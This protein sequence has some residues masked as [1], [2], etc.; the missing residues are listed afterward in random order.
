MHYCPY[1][2]PIAPGSDETNEIFIY[3]YVRDRYT[4][5]FIPNARVYQDGHLIGITDSS[6]NPINITTAKNVS[7]QYSAR[8][9]GYAES[10][11][12]DGGAAS[13][14]ATLYLDPALQNA[15]KLHLNITPKTNMSVWIDGV[16]Q[17]EANGNNPE[18]G[19]LYNGILERWI[20]IGDHTLYITALNHRPYGPE[21]I[22]VTESGYTQNIDLVDLGTL[23]YNVVVES[24]PTNIDR[25]GGTGNLEVAVFDNFESP[26]TILK[27]VPDAY[28][29]F[30]VNSLV[31]D[32][33][34]HIY[35]ANITFASYAHS[36]ASTFGS[37]IVSA[38][39]YYRG[40]DG[41]T[42]DSSQGKVRR[43][44]VH[45]RPYTNEE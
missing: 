42:V 21:V 32:P 35:T 13:G 27:I 1:I 3:V 4:N 6:A 14:N 15:R 29:D 30:T 22:E 10:S 19:V 11:S 20:S 36:S 43:Q 25:S 18:D 37:G 8:A 26:C 41:T 31:E 23:H 44:L 39:V 24:S 38:Y 17:L 2:T 7:V 40:T 16:K 34:T 33:V 12:S 9:E 45:M 28:D 5:S